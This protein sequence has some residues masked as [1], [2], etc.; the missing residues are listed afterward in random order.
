MVVFEMARLV[1]IRTDYNIK[2][3]ANPLLSVAIAFSLLLQVAVIHIPAF[4]R[5]FNVNALLASHWFYIFIL[6]CVLIAVMKL[7]NKPFN[8]LGREHH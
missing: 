4:A 6:S 8:I 1:D 5:L 3:L 2:W 7:L